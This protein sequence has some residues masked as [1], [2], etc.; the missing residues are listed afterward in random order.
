M[1]ASSS[2]KQSRRKFRTQLIAQLA[3]GI[4]LALLTYGALRLIK[5][6]AESELFG[7][8]S[9][10]GAGV[11]ISAGLLGFLTLM[12]GIDIF[13][14]IFF[15]LWLLKKKMHLESSDKTLRLP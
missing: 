8:L 14:A 7:W 4:T 6:T 3:V 1:T 10:S 5:G 12:I 9:L 15:V 11:G 13:W 2:E